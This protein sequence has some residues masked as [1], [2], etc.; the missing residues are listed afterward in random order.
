MTQWAYIHRR[1]I[2]FALSLFSF[3][4][5]FVINSTPVSLFPQVTFPRVVINLDAGDMPAE[6]MAIQAT[7][8]VEEAVR[9]V[10]GVLTVRSTTS[11]GS[12]DIAINFRWGVDM[13][14][15]MLQ[16]ESAINQVRSNLPARL[17]FSVRRMD[18]TVFPVLGYSLSSTKHSLVELKDM[19]LYQIRPVLSAIE[20]VSKVE[21]MG[22]AT[23]E[24]QVLVNPARIN[25]LGLNLDDIAR[26]L[27]AANVIQAVGRLEHNISSTCY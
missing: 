3:A 9:A 1:S 21:V 20:G 24:Y 22:G 14:S 18:P 7:W 16:V 6:R 11:R 17:A 27:S 15:A 19:A 25:A 23:A 12:A 26:T 13:V 8:P 2:L 4:G 5:F 10:P